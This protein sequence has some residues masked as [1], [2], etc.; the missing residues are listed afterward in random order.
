MTLS[1][2]GKLG[3]GLVLAEAQGGFWMPPKASTFAEGVDGLFDFILILSIV[4]FVG[5]MALMVYFAVKYRR[6]HVEQKTSPLKHSFKLEFLWSAIPTVLLLVI[7]AWGQRDFILMNAVPDSALDVRVTGQKW[8]WSIGYPSLGKEC[9]NKLVVPLGEPVK[10]TISSVDVL[11]SFWIPAFRLKRDAL[12]NKYTG[13]WFEATQTGDFPLYCAEYCGT[14]H[15]V[16]TGRVQVLDAEAW[17]AWVASDDCAGLDPTAADYG[18]KLFV[19][20]GCNACHSVEGVRLVGPPLNGIYGKPETMQDGSQV[21]V[22]DNYLREAI[23]DPNA[24]IVQGFAPAMPTFQGRLTDQELNG[25]IDYIK[26]LG[27]DA[28]PANP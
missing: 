8:S 25:I 26:Q 23:L 15:S 5:L 27:G 16:M 14:D 28:A 10:L 20:Y 11:H 21:T 19:K 2:L 4:F 7:F 1:L 22:D 6:T 12:P 18:E 13:Y 24:S 17:K 3:G 9:Q